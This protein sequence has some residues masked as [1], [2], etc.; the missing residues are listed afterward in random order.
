MTSRPSFILTDPYEPDGKGGGKLIKF[1]TRKDD[2]MTTEEL[3]RALQVRSDDNKA[4]IDSTNLAIA[5]VARD[6]ATNRADCMGGIDAL[7]AVVNSLKGVVVANAELHDVDVSDIGVKWDAHENKIATLRDELLRNQKHFEEMRQITKQEIEK[8]TTELKKSEE[9]RGD[10]ALCKAGIRDLDSIR[11]AFTNS[12]KGFSERVAVL[13]ESFAAFQTLR[14][15]DDAP[16]DI[17]RPMES[18]PESSADPAGAPGVDMMKS[19]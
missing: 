12:A 4:A 13:E 3:L 6:V 9:M 8:S 15:D 16:T 11:D 10:V 2:D 19:G 18:V 1:P 14:H 17:A 7:A 5:N